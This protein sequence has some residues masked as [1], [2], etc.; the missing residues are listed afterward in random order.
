MF[1]TMSANILEIKV[2]LPHNVFIRASLS[3]W[4]LKNLHIKININTSIEP[5]NRYSQLL[6]QILTQA[7]T[8]THNSHRLGTS[9]FYGDSGDMAL[10]NTF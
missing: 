8:N 5:L 2:F 4:E 9:E 6:S 1:F 10:C 3:T 7:H